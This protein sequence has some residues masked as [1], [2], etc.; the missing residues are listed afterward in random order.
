M[1]IKERIQKLIKDDFYIDHKAI[2]KTQMQ[3]KLDYVRIYDKSKKFSAIQIINISKSMIS[4]IDKKLANSYLI[5]EEVW[6]IG[7]EIALDLYI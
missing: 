1:I 3:E 7:G 5:K 6:L 2:G 4:D